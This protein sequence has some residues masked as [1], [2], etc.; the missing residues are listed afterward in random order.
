MSENITVLIEAILKDEKFVS[1]ISSMNKSLDSHSKKSEGMF[2]QLKLGWLAVAAA[3]G[4]TVLALKGIVKETIETEVNI[5]KL[6]QAL[7]NQGTY[8]KELIDTYKKQASAVQNLVK[9][10]DDEI[11]K[12]QAIFT[13]YGVQKEQM[14]GLIKATLDFA[15]A[16]NIDF[17]P[18]S[19][20]V[21]K[22]VGSETNALS[23]Q[24]VQFDSN[25]KGIEKINAVMTVL[26]DKFGGQAAA[27]AATFEGKIVSLGNSFDDFKRDI[28]K[29]IILGIQPAIDSFN[30]FLASAEG[31]EKTANV[32]RVIAGAFVILGSI[33]TGTFKNIVSSVSYVSEYMAN[34]KDYFTHLFDGTN[35]S[36][37]AAIDNAI[38][39]KE[40]I[41]N[42]IDITKTMFTDSYAGLKMLSDANAVNEQTNAQNTTTRLATENAKQVE[43]TKQ[44]V[45]AEK[46]A[47]DDYNNFKISTYQKGVDAVVTGLLDEKTAGKTNTANFMRMIADQLAAYLALKATV[48]WAE[49]LANPLMIPAAIGYTAA[50]AAVKVAGEAAAS[51][52]ESYDVGTPNVQGDQ[53]ARIHDGERII[54]AE[55][56]IPNMSNEA[57]MGATYR[58]IGS[59]GQGSS[60]STTNNNSTQ[61]INLNG[62]GINAGMGT[63]LAEL[64]DMADRMGSRSIF[65]RG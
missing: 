16:K 21:A 9:G 24:G 54:P 59:S 4:G 45:A 57:F 44:R 30:N 20:M 46:K 29:G 37:K 38:L 43:N 33:V 17:I 19:E 64:L 8:S 28:G 65:Q 12:A 1:G 27:A 26:N 40:F 10:G 42:Q 23:R 63:T 62:I 47:I 32:A 13:M 36:N 53:V 34:A 5:S 35:A 50:S 41:K 60:V 55:M 31:M 56:N 51:R 6:S 49:S 3:I 18:A 11:L 15:K 14:D 61:N 58:G 39:T 52:I 25:V 48:A 7:K 22:T 2:K